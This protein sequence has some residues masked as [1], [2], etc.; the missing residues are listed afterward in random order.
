[1]FV[2]TQLSINQRKICL[3]R[4]WLGLKKRHSSPTKDII[5][6][7]R[8]RY[9]PPSQDS[10]VQHFGLYIWAGNQ[11]YSLG[12]F[13]S[14]S[15][16]VSQL[17]EVELDWLAFELRDWLNLPT[18]TFGEVTTSEHQSQIAADAMNAEFN[19][20]DSASKSA[21]LISPTPP[22]ELF[23]ISRPANALCTLTKITETIEISAPAE[24]SFCRQPVGCVTCILSVYL[25]IGG[26][27]MIHAGLALLL[28][29]AVPVVWWKICNL[30]DKHRQATRIVL[31]IDQH[32]ISLYEQFQ[33]KQRRCLKKMALSQIHKL[34]LVYQNRQGCHVKISARDPSNTLKDSFF[35]VGNRSFWLSQKEAEW[36]AYELSIYL[37]LPVTEVEV[38]ENSDL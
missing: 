32:D 17:T 24:S 34:Q 8:L 25:L 9:K 16:G 22:S 29:G 13:S 15:G 11:R 19:S 12:A 18:Q 10:E 4:D 36:L 20:I 3:T 2:K 7:E 27:T 26:A 31:Q 6:L 28:L 33:S 21:L 14:T 5:K 23:R 30:L 38:I 1:M 35:L 37:K